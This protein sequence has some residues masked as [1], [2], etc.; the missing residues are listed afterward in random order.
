[1]V[2]SFVGTL[3]ISCSFGLIRCNCYADLY[4]MEHS[5]IVATILDDRRINRLDFLFAFNVAILHLYLIRL[6][7]EFTSTLEVVQCSC[8]DV[9]LCTMLCKDAEVLLST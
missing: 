9:V 5:N 7:H 6:C 4:S 3:T 2:R 8:N 1:M